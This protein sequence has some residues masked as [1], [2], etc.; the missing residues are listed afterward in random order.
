MIILI[1][2]WT[3]QSTAS[4]QRASNLPLPAPQELRRGPTLT[5]VAPKYVQDA[6][7]LL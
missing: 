1:S 6:V 2:S 5:M 7:G 4:A 3:A